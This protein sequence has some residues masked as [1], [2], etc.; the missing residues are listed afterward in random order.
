MKRQRRF[1]GNIAA[2]DQHLSK[3]KGMKSVFTVLL[4]QNIK[5]AFD[6]NERSRLQGALYLA[7]APVIAAAQDAP[8]LL[9]VQD[10][11][12]VTGAFNL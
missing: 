1:H 8:N 7:I 10:P 9:I 12:R 4:S 11:I 6:P 2:W 5:T 3:R